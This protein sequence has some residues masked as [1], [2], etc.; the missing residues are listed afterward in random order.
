M[1]CP[2][3]TLSA[4]PLTTIQ[5]K[6]LNQGDV[7]THLQR[8]EKG[9]TLTVI[10]WI[11]APPAQVWKALSETA[12]QKVIYPSVLS[13]A[14]ERVQADGSEVQRAVFDFPW[15]FDDRW[16]LHRAVKS[17]STCT[18]SWERIDGTLTGNTGSWTLYQSEDGKST[19]LY[20]RVFF[21]PGLPLVPESLIQYGM[22]KEAPGI[23]THLRRF[24]SNP[25]AEF[26][27]SAS[28]MNGSCAVE[29]KM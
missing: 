17:P 3:V 28:E 1:A 16:S 4:L 23:V 11:E 8:H 21:D 2:T 22:K 25:T 14:V 26:R 9:G 18:L 10:G 24:L 7:L 5:R 20:Y 15:P 29:R 27:A 6:S 19:L 13:S 12:L